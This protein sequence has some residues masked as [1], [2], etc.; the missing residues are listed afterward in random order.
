MRRAA[1]VYPVL[2]ASVSRTFADMVVFGY[3]PL[4][5]FAAGQSDVLHLSLVTAV[6]A[7][8][9]FVSSNLWG[10]LADVTGRIKPALV[11]G[12]AAY[13]GACLALLRASTGLQAALV[14]SVAA[15]LYGGLAPAAKALLSLRPGPLGTP[16][17]ALAW[18]LQLESWGWALGSAAVALRERLGL[19]SEA[20]LVA[21][22]A[23]LGADLVWLAL[24]V[25]EPTPS[26]PSGRLGQSLSRRAARLA[27]EWRQ[28]YGRGEMAL[29][30]AVFALATLAG[31]AAF[32]VF[33]FYLVGTLG[34]SESLYGATVALATGLGLVAYA[35]L[36][37]RGQRYSAGDLIAAGALLYV[38]MFATMAGAPS[39]LVAAGAF[40]LPLYPLVRAGVTWSAGALTAEHERGGGMGALDGVEALATT[41][42]AV[43][44]GAVGRAWGL[45]AVYAGCAAAALV[46]SA[47]AWRL[48]VVLARRPARPVAARA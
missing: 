22:A 20:L 10:A 32:T 13:A 19:P 17:R 4:Q 25:R 2:A 37:G 48:R 27:G 14:V 21:A 45:R 42:G 34:G 43:A 39:A 15:A 33:G 30:L 38:A 26:G 16:R 18:W 12:V 40:A 9:R 24:A 47:A 7:T 36:G 1:S 11:V 29:L 44:A 23:V 28:L 3:V 6:P 8:V 46:L 31:E 35:W 41:L 5:L